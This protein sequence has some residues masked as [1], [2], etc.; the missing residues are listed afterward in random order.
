MIQTAYGTSVVR[1]CTWR[2]LRRQ[3]DRRVGDAQAHLGE[4]MQLRDVGVGQSVGTPRGLLELATF[5]QAC[6][7]RSRNAGII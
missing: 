6:E 4:A 1:P 3:T 7:I 2:A 5:D